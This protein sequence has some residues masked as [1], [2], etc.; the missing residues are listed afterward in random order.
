M[1]PQPLTVSHFIVEWGGSRINFT[2]VYGLDII[3]EIT[4]IHEGGDKGE[5][6]RK[7]P[8]LRKYSNVVL[9]RGMVAGDNEFYAW[10]NTTN[11]NEIEKRDV[12]IHLLNQDNS[13][14]FS[15]QVINAF[16]AKLLG[17]VLN[18][19]ENNIAIETLELAHDGLTVIAS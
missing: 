12:V 18:A 7:L 11:F 2:E 17:P 13:P 9:K 1:E 6:V 14:V 19:A 3:N 16:P 15:W 5:Q 8:G 4:E 10:M